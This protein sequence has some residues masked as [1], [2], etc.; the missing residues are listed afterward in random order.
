MH[1]DDPLLA[2]GHP[3]RIGHED[4]PAILEAKGEGD[5]RRGVEGTADVVDVHDR[6][7]LGC[8]RSRRWRRRDRL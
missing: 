8:K 3:A 1:Y 6:H 4:F 5:E 7:S 2:E